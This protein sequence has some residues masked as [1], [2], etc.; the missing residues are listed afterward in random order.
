MADEVPSHR[1]MVLMG[2]RDIKTTLMYYV[3]VDNSHDDTVRAALTF[4]TATTPEPAPE[5][6]T[7]SSFDPVGPNLRLVG[8]FDNIETVAKPLAS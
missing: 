6:S 7:R 1:L 3:N 5:P 4:D 2:H 8:S